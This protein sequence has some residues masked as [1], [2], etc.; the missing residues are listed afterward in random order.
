MLTVGGWFALT[1]IV[2]EWDADAPPKSVAVNV[3]ACVPSDRSSRVKDA[4]VPM[5]A[6]MLDVQTKL[7]PFNAPS[8]GSV[9]VPR[10]ATASPWEDSAPSA[11][12]VMLTVG[13]AFR[14][15][16]LPLPPPPSHALKNNTSTTISGHEVE[17]TL[18]IG[19]TSLPNLFKDTFLPIRLYEKICTVQARILLASLALPSRLTRAKS[20]AERVRGPGNHVPAIAGLFNGLPVINASSAKS[21]L[22]LKVARTI[23]L[24]QVDINFP[25][26][27]RF[28]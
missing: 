3:M 1:R 19:P 27:E 26:S 23:S 10:N 8:S 7:A 13:T 18:F 28:S 21:P 4:P 25:S 12:L 6:S 20:S 11:G 14:A 17:M 5:L 2:I 16:P 24:N 22:P 15:A 9:A